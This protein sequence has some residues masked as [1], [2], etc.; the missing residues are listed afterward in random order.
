[1]AK[2]EIKWTLSVTYNESMETKKYVN[3]RESKQIQHNSKEIERPFNNL[4]LGHLSIFREKSGNEPLE[5]KQSIDIALL[6]SEKVH[7]V[8]TY[9]VTFVVTLQL[10]ITVV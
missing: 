3:S 1:M 6:E 5:M 2:T 8:I 9:K 4:S 7:M 10:D